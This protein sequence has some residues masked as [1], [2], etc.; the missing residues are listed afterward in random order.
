MDGS[1]TDVVADDV[2]VREPLLTRFGVLWHEGYRV[3]LP[4]LRECVG[5]IRLNHN[6]T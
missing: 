4:V 3:L 5:N 2:M 6:T 1:E